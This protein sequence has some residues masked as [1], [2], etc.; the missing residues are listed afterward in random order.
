M[1]VEVNE[2]DFGAE[3]YELRIQSRSIPRVNAC[4]ATPGALSILAFRA[5]SCI[6]Q[7]GITLRIVEEAILAALLQ[8]IPGGEIIES[9]RGFCRCISTGSKTK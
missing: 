1:T 6:A 4:P 7:C 2:A 3:L 9:A 5:L 8:A